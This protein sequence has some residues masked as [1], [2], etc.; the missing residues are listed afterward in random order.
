MCVK[1]E[2]NKGTVVVFGISVLFSLV[3]IS[4]A[5]IKADTFRVQWDM[6]IET[7][8]LLSFTVD[9]DNNLYF[10]FYNPSEHDYVYSKVSEDG[11]VHYDKTLSPKPNYNFSRIDNYG[12]RYFIY[13]EEKVYVYSIYGK[14]F[15]ITKFTDD[16]VYASTSFVN[17]SIYF[18]GNFTG[19]LYYVDSDC[20]YFAILEYQS[21]VDILLSIQLVKFTITGEKLWNRTITSD[22]CRNNFDFCKN[23]N[24]NIFIGYDGILYYLVDENGAVIWQQTII[25]EEP[26]IEY[27]DQELMAYQ[28][29]VMLVAWTIDGKLF[30]KLWTLDNSTGW[31]LVYTAES[32]STQPT[33]HSS[34]CVVEGDYL[35]IVTREHIYDVD[36]KELTSIYHLR[37][38][39][40]E[41]EVLY[42]ERVEIVEIVD[43]DETGFEINRKMKLYPT[44][45]GNFYLYEFLYYKANDEDESTIKYCIPN[46]GFTPGYTFAITFT[47][48]SILNLAVV[49]RKRMLK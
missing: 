6:N 37:L 3:I 28:E 5:F 42:T 1:I 24:G 14:E 16:L 17:L 23:A 25:I 38:L 12:N 7:N 47:S 26:T 21:D 41:K 49:I 10:S 39:N 4:P 30:L 34:S 13:V 44:N 31:E 8:S 27:Y 32:T 48:V 46:P 40:E 35:G 15:T 33:F 19:Y 22:P 18:E 9:A 11:L 36:D 20:A 43:V 2:I 29:N 45:D